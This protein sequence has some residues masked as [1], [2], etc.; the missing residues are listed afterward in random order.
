MAV[1]SQ[2]PASG[3]AET[4]GVIQYANVPVGKL[5][6]LYLAAGISTRINALRVDN[7]TRSFI[8]IKETGD[9]IWPMTLGWQKS[10][11]PGYTQVTITWPEQVGSMYG[12]DHSEQASAFITFTDYQWSDDG[13][14]TVLNSMSDLFHD[15]IPFG[16]LDQVFDVIKRTPTTYLSD[17]DQAITQDA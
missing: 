15:D 4:Q 11:K 7:P 9:L 17:I 1:R 5:T 6:P 2:Q 13:G 16:F 14:R 12:G 8:Q 10:L 3:P